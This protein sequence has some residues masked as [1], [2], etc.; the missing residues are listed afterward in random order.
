ME[1]N[2]DNWQRD[3]FYALLSYGILFLALWAL[4]S[5]ST[6]KVVSDNDSNHVHT[7]TSLISSADSSVHRQVSTDSIV[8]II[9]RVDTIHDV[10]VVSDSVIIDRSTETVITN[11]VNADGVIIGTERVTTHNNNRDHYRNENSDIR[12]ISELTNKMLQRHNDSIY[13]Q[14]QHRYDSLVSVIDSLQQSSNT[15]IE[16]DPRNWWQRL[17]DRV[18]EYLL[19]ALVILLA[20]VVMYYAAKY[21]MGK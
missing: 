21:Y 20:A 19:H 17:Q 3:V 1:Y 15:V 12:Q 18:G 11:T 8:H 7:E 4:S 9:S 6:Q 2:R 5:C 14:Y 16:K 10:K 13:D